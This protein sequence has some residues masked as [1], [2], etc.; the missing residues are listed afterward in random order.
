L[1]FELDFCA[2]GLGAGAVQ[3]RIGNRQIK[4]VG[5]ATADGT[6]LDHQIVKD[7]A[8]DGAH[9][10]AAVGQAQQDVFDVPVGLLG[11][12]VLLKA[13]SFAQ[14]ARRGA[15]ISIAQDRRHRRYVLP[16]RG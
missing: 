9:E 8:R 4:D 16:C 2:G 15:G 12:F 13:E 14:P 6:W 7:R 11:T 3:L 10:H 5:V 1:R